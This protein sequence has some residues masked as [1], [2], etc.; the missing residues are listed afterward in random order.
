MKKIG[1]CELINAGLS[2]QKVG[3]RQ[4]TSFKLF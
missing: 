4:Q 1:Q 2:H 3:V